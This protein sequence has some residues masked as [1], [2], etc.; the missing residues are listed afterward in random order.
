MSTIRKHNMLSHGDRV[1]LGLS[2]GADSMCLLHILY[3]LRESYG[4]NIICAHIN[5]GIRQS[6]DRDEAF[7]K[8]V[9]EALGVPLEIFRVD[10]GAY[11]RKLKASRFKVGIE[12]AGR[13]LRYGYFEDCGRKLGETFKIAT[14]HSL[15]DQAETVLMRLL[16]GAGTR[17]LHGIPPVR[18]NI[19]RP[20]I[21]V[22]RSD[23]EAYCAEHGITYVQDETNLENNYT[24]NKLRNELIPYIAREFNPS[25]VDTLAR[26]AAIYYSENDY[27]YEQAGIALDDCMQDLNLGVINLDIAKL[28]SLH[29]ALSSRVIRRAINMICTEDVY[30][31][32]IESALSIARGQTGKSANI[33]GGVTAEKIYGSL[34]LCIY[35]GSLR[36]CSCGWCPPPGF[37][38][39]LTPD[40][41]TYIPEIEKSILVSLQKPSNL[42]PGALYRAFKA[43][44]PLMLRTRLPGDRIG[45]KKLKDYF[46]DRK[47]P[48]SERAQT[49]LLA[50]GSDILWIMD[51]RG[52]ISKKYAPDEDP[53]GSIYVSIWRTGQC[54]QQQR[55][56]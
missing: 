44:A 22:S 54:D 6:S 43:N 15:N 23:I 2:G 3:K 16:R 26:S 41:V 42:P 18:Q 56:L 30:H 53:H 20:L 17:G 49:P 14:A 11:A 55:K 21:D 39:E 45:S 37:T 40:T 32:H 13:R 52:L 4:L 35:A 24:R 31:T 27:M 34:R 36:K 10:V 8:T 7:V 28:L 38:Y 33:C 29:D 1:V 47:I 5:H 46:I 12:A 51:E 9:C 25:I 19:I 50:H 48:Q